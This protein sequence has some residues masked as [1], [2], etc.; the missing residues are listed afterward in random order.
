MRCAVA[1]AVVL[2]LTGTVQAEA[3]LEYTQ[4]VV[5]RQASRARK[6]RIVTGV[7][8]AASGVAL[9]AGGFHVLAN[10]KEGGLIDLSG[11]EKALAYSMIGAGGVLAIASPLLMLTRSYAEVLR[12]DITDE[13]DARLVRTEVAH[14]AK[15]MRRTR[16]VVRGIGVVLAGVGAIGVTAAAASGDSLDDAPRNDLMGAGISLGLLGSGLVIGS[17]IETRWETMHR[18]L[19]VPTVELSAGLVPVRGGAIAGVGGTF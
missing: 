14:R 12:D 19:T 4:A 16:M 18:E 2:S 8:M 11:L 6:V 17:L 5:G 15:Q 7:A 1:L 3:T 13:N 10:V 9:G